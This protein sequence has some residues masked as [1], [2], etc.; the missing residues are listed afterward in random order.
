M[1][2]CKL[3][4]K[5]ELFL[6]FSK[7][8]LCSNCEKFFI[9]DLENRIRIIK[10][11]QRIINISKK[12]D[13]RLSRCKIL[14]EQIIKLL[15]YQNKNIN[16]T[17]ILT[18]RPSLPEFYNVCKET[19]KEILN[20]KTKLEELLSICPYC[21][22]RLEKIVKRSK[23]CPNCNN[24]I[25]VKNGKLYKIEEYEDLIEAEEKQRMKENIENLRKCLLGYKNA[26]IKYV[27]ILTAYDGCENCKK[28]DGKKIPIN[29]AIKK[30]ILPNKECTDEFI[31]CRCCYAAIVDIK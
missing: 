7:Y 10:D 8:G 11:C 22:K 19:Y 26:G 21:K 13:T 4:G 5:W 28:W 9:M 16:L 2:N 31:G 15:E 24:Q 3:C 29:E 17:K 14:E 23:K 18:L 6:F 27:E 25:I 12:I 30:N 20:E 1:G